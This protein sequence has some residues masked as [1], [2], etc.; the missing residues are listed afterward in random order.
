MTDR[1]RRPERGKALDVPSPPPPPRWTPLEAQPHTEHMH[2]G[3]DGQV[4]MTAI[5]PRLTPLPP[6]D[7]H[8]PW[9]KCSRVCGGDQ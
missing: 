1:S 3:L 4:D 6:I 8:P 5:E 7:E 2:V 9:C